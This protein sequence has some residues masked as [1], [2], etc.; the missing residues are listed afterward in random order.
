M[1]ER[2]AS[3]A[4]RTVGIEQE[5]RKQGIEIIYSEPVHVP[6][7]VWQ[8]LEALPDAQRR[9]MQLFLD[10]L[11]LSCSEY[12]NGI[13]MRDSF[14]NEHK[15]LRKA[16]RERMFEEHGDDFLA[17]D[18]RNKLR[19]NLING[20]ADALRSTVKELNKFDVHNSQAD[21]LRS[22]AEKVPPVSTSYYLTLSED[23]KMQV[24]NSTDQ[25]AR[26]TLAILANPG[27]IDEHHA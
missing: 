21:S 11:Y 15:T 17:L 4:D 23:E 12:A 18:R 9:T 24:V 6:A 19:F 7:L 2:L 25:I 3:K 13:L 16:W 22:L 14:G 5:F 10:A 27:I 1:I 26:E 8:E 20:V